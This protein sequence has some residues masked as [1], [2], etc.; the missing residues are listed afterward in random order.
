MRL[1]RVC[2]QLI[3]LLVLAV[4]ASAQSRPDPADDLLRKAR[5]FAEAGKF[6]EALK[7]YK[8]ANKRSN[9]NC[10]AC[11]L[12]MAM[13][14]AK[15][16]DAKAAL[17]SSDKALKVS[18]DDPSRALGHNMR[19][20]ALLAL[21]AEQPKKLSEAESAF[22]QAVQLQPA[23]A[24]YH[25]NLGVAL[26]KLMR[27]ED[28]VAEFKRALQLAPQ[29]DAAEMAQS[30]VQN[31]RRAREPVAPDFQIE[32]VNGGK[33]A[34]H[35]FA[36]K[37]VVLDF[38]ATWCA[39]CRAS[40]PDIKDLIKKYGNER[41]V[42]ISI[43]WDQ[44]EKAWR[45]FIAKHEMGWT[46]ARDPESDLSHKLGVRA[47]PTYLVIDGDGFIK[48]RIVGTNAQQSLAYR[49]REKLQSMPQLAKK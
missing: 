29:G 22:R 35:D 33:I 48:E 7:A 36:G 5:E 20:H 32:S 44:D 12:G 46:H 38:W 37:V 4:V 49:L 21:A 17:E 8:D 47:V 43:S 34:L 18:T 45:D 11:Y 26:A 30:F 28:A 1:R 3:T 39:P 2:A 6:E 40:V 13:T 9:G 25:V 16:G 42:V 10:S 27:D 23:N 19:G 15:I 14:A 24:S 41:L 31:P